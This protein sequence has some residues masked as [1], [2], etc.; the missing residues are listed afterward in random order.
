[1]CSSDLIVADG[2]KDKVL[3]ALQSAP[4]KTS[5]EVSA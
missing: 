2:P 5:A 1:V 3:A 4:V